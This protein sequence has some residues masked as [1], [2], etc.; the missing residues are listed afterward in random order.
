MKEASSGKL[1]RY[2]MTDKIKV[3]HDINN[4]GH[5]EKSVII[6]ELAAG[7]SY[8]YE[9]DG[10][11]DNVLNQLFDQ[12][13]INKSTTEKVADLIIQY[14]KVTKAAQSFSSDKYI[15][16]DTY[17]KEDENFNTKTMIIVDG[18]HKEF[19]VAKTEFYSESKRIESELSKI[20]NS[21]MY[22]LRFHDS[23]MAWFDTEYISVT[24]KK[25][26]MYFPTQIMGIVGTSP[27]EEDE[28]SQ[29]FWEKIFLPFLQRK[30]KIFDYDYVEYIQGLK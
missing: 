7:L 29:A 13:G 4:I 14:E 28:H 22:T 11:D 12:K 19:D 23:I 17:R 26:T 15:P 30:H 2:Y 1:V 5:R 16:Y 20:V 18:V 6:G 24:T 27:F 25:T 3:T 10:V 9:L 21:Q 8:L